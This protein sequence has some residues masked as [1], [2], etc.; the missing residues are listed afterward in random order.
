MDRRYRTGYG[1]RVALAG[2][3]L[4]LGMTTTVRSGLYWNAGIRSQ[5]ITVCFVGDA[6]TSRPSRVQQILSYIKNFEYATNV[7][8]SSLGTCPA[9][10]QQANGKDFYDGDIRVV[11]PNTSVDATVPVPGNGC[12][13][14][15]A[16][17][18]WGSWSN[19]PNDLTPNRS[20]LYNLKLGDDP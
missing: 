8:F 12:P 19:A 13:P 1:A 4:M 20:C 16:N 6:L 10:T 2:G 5:V 18:G 17:S 7:R 9:A 11:I 15:G 3:A 14:G